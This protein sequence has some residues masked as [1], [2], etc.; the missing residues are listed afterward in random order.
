MILMN[1][2]LVWFVLGLFLMVMEFFVPGVL[3]VFFG[4]S[5][6]IV[7]VTT[8]IGLTGSSASQLVLFALGAVCLIALLRKWVR[9]KFIGHVTDIQNLDTNMDD[10]IGR[11]AIVLEKIPGS[12]GYGAVEFKG[13]RWR[14][15]SEEFHPEGASVRIVSRDGLTFKVE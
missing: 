7:A 13:A 14:A 12:D 15:I 4:V 3:L 9:D 8:L 11:T 2:V 10:F 5:A 6:W 1:P